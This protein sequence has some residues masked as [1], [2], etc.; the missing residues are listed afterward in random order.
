LTSRRN[1]CGW[2]NRSASLLWSEVPEHRCRLEQTNIISMKTCPTCNRTYAD[3]SLTYCLADGSLLSAPYDPEVTQRLHLPP[4]SNSAQTE[5]LLSNSQSG[6]KTSNSSLKY[7]VLVILILIAAVGL[8]VWFNSRAKE[9][10][11]ATASSTRSSA[12]D[13]TY[14]PGNVLDQSLATAW[15]EGVSG[16]GR[17]EWLRC[18]F[19]REVKL[20]RI[21]ITPGYFKTREL[22]VLLRRY[23]E[24]GLLVI[25][26]VL[27][28]CF[29][30]EAT[31]KYPD[32]I[33]GP[34]CL[35]LSVFQAANSPQR[36]LDTMARSEQDAVFIKVGHR[37]LEAHAVRQKARQQSTACTR[38]RISV[39]FIV[40]LA[41][42]TLCARRVMPGV[43]RFC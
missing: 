18:D 5:V 33:L 13:I 21:I 15:S 40:N 37:L 34:E 17:G 30:S 4:S 23:Q 7:I 19:N 20:N 38:P 8:M 28:Y 10:I 1:P 39:P 16:P 43:R 2:R 35:P 29:F 32:P 25:P 31:F 27:R 22:P 6:K 11:T 41:F 9:A 3:E 26:I 14:Q 24:N 12:G 36:P 42:I